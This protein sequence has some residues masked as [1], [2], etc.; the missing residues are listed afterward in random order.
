[1]IDKK[2][3]GKRIKE[4]R[5]SL[6]LNQGEFSGNL[7]IS[8]TAISEIETGKFKPNIELLALLSKVYNVNLYF[9]IFNEGDMFLDPATFISQSKKKYAVNIDDIRKFFYYFE[10]SS[11]FQ[12][13]IMAIFKTKLLR[14][15]EIFQEDIDSNQSR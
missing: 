5:K 10:R 14:E 3:I 4:I 12:Y 7:S 2:E 9:V 13:E 11:I 15:K 8:S 6:G 1:M